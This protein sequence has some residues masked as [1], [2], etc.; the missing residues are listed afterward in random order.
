MFAYVLIGLEM[1]ILSSVFWYV[2]IRE[3]KPFRISKSDLWGS[4]E[5][6]E[7][8]SSQ[9]ELD[10]LVMEYKRNAHNQIL[11]DRRVPR[12]ANPEMVPK[13]AS[14]FR[15]PAFGIGGLD[16]GWHQLYNRNQLPPS[17]NE[18]TYGWVRIPERKTD[19][20]FV[21]LLRSAWCWIENLSVKLP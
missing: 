15:D 8:F 18:K 5:G 16:D 21:R 13:Y 17:K 19:N 9:L 7:P 12:F 14:D 4:Y 10:T 2:F 11:V 1:L 6:Y 20:N 3:P